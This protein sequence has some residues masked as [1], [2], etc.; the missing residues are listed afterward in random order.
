[1][2]PKPRVFALAL[3]VAIAA[4]VACLP[5]VAQPRP[6]PP[7]PTAVYIEAARNQI[8]FKFGKALAGRY[9][10][11]PNVAKPY[12]WPLNAPNGEP[13]TRAWPMVKEGAAQTDHVHQKSAWFCYGDVIPEG[14]PLKH[15]IRGVEGVDFWS[16]APGHGKIVCVDV[17]GILQDK[18]HGRV[19]TLNEWRT[20]DDVKIMD[21][22]R[23]IHLY[24]FGDAQLFVLDI[25][26]VASVVPITFGD[27]KEGALGVRVRTSLTEDKGQGKLTNAEGKTGEGK[28]GNRDRTGCWGLV[29][30]WCD[31][32]GPVGRTTAGIALFA[33]PTN[34]YATAWHARGYG[35]LAANPFGRAKSGFPAMKGNTQRVK[36]AKG[37]HLKLRYG[38]FLHLGDVKEGKVA[39]YYDRFVALKKSEG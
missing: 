15:K 24:N 36:L 30:K 12:F 3:F 31:D 27:T 33:D 26:L 17:G 22:K 16:E 39:Q 19:I 9:V 4:A 28:N 5:V 21:E 1:M 25:D 35:L 37:E 11:G 2:L 38:I 10:L 32:S 29:S 14:I 8:D 18:N 20:A 23:T 13:I 6:A 34:P 7:G